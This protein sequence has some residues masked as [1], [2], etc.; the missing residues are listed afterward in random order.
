MPKGKLPAGTFSRKGRPRLVPVT[1]GGPFDTRSGFYRDNIVVTARPVWPR[2]L[3]GAAAQAR[4]LLGDP[5]ADAGRG[6]S[7]GCGDE[8][9]DVH[10]AG[11]RGASRAFPRA[12]ARA[13]RGRARIRRVLVLTRAEVDS[14]LDPGELIEVVAAAMADLS[15]GRASMPN[16]IAAFAGEHDGLLAAMPAYVPA[17]GALATKLVTLFPGNAGGPL[18]THQALIG[19][20]DPATGEPAAIMDGT[21]ITALRTAAGSA[22]AT[23]LLARA[24]ARV[25]AIVGTG[26]QARAHA[27]AVPLVRSF[28]ELRVGGR[29]R[30]KTDA[31]AA[32]LRA[33][34]LP[35]VAA[36]SIE[37]AVRG[38]DVVCA[39]TH[40]RAPV[41]AREWL[42]PGTHVTSVGYDPEGAEVDTATIRD[43][44]VVVESR[45]TALAPPPAGATELAHA[46]AA[47]AIGREHVH[48]ELGEL[49]AGTRPGRPDERAITL[50]KSVGVGVQDAAA[51]ALVL[52]RARERGVGTAIEL[53]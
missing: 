28:D 7:D 48:A 37:A 5:E 47:G 43:A 51:A 14:L 19:V 35:A 17:N 13:R 29:D 27:R 2:G 15:A 21:A 49:V 6:R 23:R 18:P 11:T 9:S 22:L 8:D 32:E 42:A 25:L 50:Y 36:P 3:G 41:L 31:L 34:G 24:D 12:P 52:D 44:L 10:A 16:R 40:A 38:A 20:F 45:A 4:A 33:A 1:C 26:V 39:T 53:G 30:G 46:I